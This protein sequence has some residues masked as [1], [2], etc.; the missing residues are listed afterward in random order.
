MFERDK[1][2]K[3]LKWHLG[4]DSRSNGCRQLREQLDVW[5]AE[6]TPKLCEQQVENTHRGYSGYSR[7]LLR[8]WR[9]HWRRA[10]TADPSCP[11]EASQVADDIRNGQGYRGGGRLGGDPLRDVML[12]AAML[13]KENKAASCFQA[14]YRGIC[15]H[16][17]RGLGPKL[18]DQIDEW[19]N[20]LLDHLA[21]YTRSQPAG[22]LARFQGRSALH[23]WL[24]P[25]LWNFL[26]GWLRGH[27]RQIPLL[28]EEPDRQRSAE[29][30]NSVDDTE[31]CAQLESAFP[32][33]VRLLPYEELLVLSTR[34]LDGLNFKQIAA[35]LGK[36]EGTA[37]RIHQRALNRL[38][39]AIGRL[40][41]EDATDSGN[42]SGSLP[43]DKRQAA[44]LL[45]QALEDARIEDTLFDEN[46]TDQ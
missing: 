20:E 21:G 36:A 8:C 1:K 5:L 44:D 30:C 25:V 15:E 40:L 9:W 38:R 41:G 3:W 42:L 24:R 43:V 28:E 27:G 6:Y 14:E 22:K 26:K 12:A 23:Y 17:A 39:H 29:E 4:R 46:P 18:G 31:G 13:D 45:W 11:L 19:W 16:Q 35:M 33:A 2:W 10:L 37:V 7:R 34:Y 32:E